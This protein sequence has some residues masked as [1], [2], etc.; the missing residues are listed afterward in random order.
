MISDS[1]S[2]WS[3]IRQKNRSA[4]IPGEIIY[5][6]LEYYDNKVIVDLSAKFVES[7]LP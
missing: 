7:V 1:K 2:F 3:I 5:D 4:R 6:G